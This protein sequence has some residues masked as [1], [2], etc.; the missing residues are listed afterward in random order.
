MIKKLC[1]ICFIMIATITVACAHTADIKNSGQN[2]YKMIRLT[3]EIY[4]HSNYDLSDI[5]IKD[6][7]GNDVPYFIHSSN[8]TTSSGKSQYPLV[9]ID[10]YIKDDFFYFDYKLSKNYEHDIVSTSLALSTN[11]TNFAKQIEVY[12]SFDGKKW[13]KIQDDTIYHVDNNKKLEITFLTP[14]KFTHFRFKLSNNL[15]KIEFTNAELRYNVTT[16]ENSYFTAQLQPEFTVE[17]KGTNTYIHVKQVKNLKLDEITIVSDSIFKR[18]ASTPKGSQEIY[19]LSFGNEIYSDTTIK[20]DQY[21]SKDDVLTAVIHNNDDKPIKISAIKVK[22]F[23]DELVFNGGTGTASKL[24][25]GND[26][27]ALKPNY[28]IENYKNDVLKQS[29]DKLELSNIIISQSAKMTNFN[30]S[31]LFNITIIV[32]TILLGIILILKLKKTT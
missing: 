26:P 13:S 8:Q 14:Q 32:V 4:N 10:S 9:L 24:E 11:N 1:V 21:I 19:H 5:R 16:R 18:N 3:P 20:M 2:K 15:E 6:D 31:T 29:I 30:Y 25:F 27:T 17:E 12:G 22:Y 23:E 7:S 28:D